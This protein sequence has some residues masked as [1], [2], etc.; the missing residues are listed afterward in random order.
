AAV[1]VRTG[2]LRSCALFDGTSVQRDG[3]SRFVAMDAAAPA[4]ADCSD[5][6]LALALD[7]GCALAEWPGCDATCPDGGVCTPEVIGGP[8][9]CVYPT[10]P[11][12]T[13]AP[14]CSGECPAGEQCYPMDGFIP[15]PVDSCACGQIGE[16]PCGASGQ[17]CDSGGCPDGLV[18][19]T[20]P[21]VGI[22]DSY[23]NCMNP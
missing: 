8:C 1:R 23:C 10:Q 9:R 11:C 18:C 15:G 2:S 22:Y 7:A 4:L 14:L 17:S 13:T 3:E 12:G 5:E 19:G 20:V 6:T 21:K 16:P